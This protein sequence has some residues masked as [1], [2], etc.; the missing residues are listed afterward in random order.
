M[1][2]FLL[3][4]LLAVMSLALFG[5]GAKDDGTTKKGSD[6]KKS[7]ATTITY[8]SWNLGTEED[9]NLYRRLVNKFN[10]DNDDIQIKL[11]E[12]EG[13]YN[14]FL[15]TMASGRQ[16]PDV[17]MVN[18]VPTAVINY[19]AGDITSVVS[20]DPEW[21]TINEALRDSITYDGH[22]FGIPCGQY[23]MG[24]FANY[25]L[26]DNYLTGG[27][28]AMEV[29][30]PGVFTTQTFIDTVKQ[31]RN[32]VTNGASTIGVN[33]VGDMIN[34]LPSTL[35]TTGK[36]S[37]FVW[38]G[39]EKK[40]EYRSEEM[41]NA[42]TTINDL[43]DYCFDNTPVTEENTIE[44][45]FS[46]G[47]SSDAFKNGQ[48]GFY[49]SG[50]W[51]TFE[52]SDTLNYMFVGYPGGKIVS[53][54]DYMCISRST[55]DL[56]AAYKVAKYLS[57]GYDGTMAKFDIIDANP[58]AKLTVSGLPIVNNTE[59][60]NKWFDYVTLKGAKQCYLKVVS[61]EMDL[62]V[63]GN[64]SIPGFQDARF[65]GSTGLSYEDVRGGSVLNMSDFI[66]DVCSG[67]ISVNTYISDMSPEL[68]ALFNK[69]VSD[70]YEKIQKVLSK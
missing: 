58:D 19:L 8:C 33:A 13:D 46:T 45:F 68:E 16:L 5:C 50:T 18:S 41:I 56:N 34:W 42:L 51:D 65:L 7:N 10:N 24:F 31:M 22:V 55:K 14:T 9:N 17:F 35:D 30:E 36:I 25:Q 49:Q 60:A 69:Y 70:A 3:F 54:S 47:S 12:P 26:I 63:E 39:A 44:T 6:P 43:S 4:T 37:H 2:K 29:F 62:L 32:F 38:N 66:W 67:K 40:F 61:G 53:A 28:D 64:K 27:K 23:Y 1:K 52:D 15:T 11:V 20:E 48:I 59:I 21:A 57:F